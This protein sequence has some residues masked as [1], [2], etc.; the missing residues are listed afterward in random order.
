VPRCRSRV[1]LLLA[2]LRAWRQRQSQ[3]R[4][5]GRLVS[6]GDLV[7]DVGA[8]V[9]DRT[10]VLA[11][12][13]ARVVAVEPQEDCVRKLSRR[14]RE[15]QRVTVVPMGLG[16]QEGFQDLYVSSIHPLS[17]M[18]PAFVEATRRSGRFASVEWRERL[19]VPVTTLDQL[20]DRYGRPVFC[21]ID[22]EGYEAEVLRGLTAPLPLLSIEF[23]CE[24][25]GA[26][27][28]AVSYVESLGPSEFNYSLGESME[29][30]ADEWIT[31]PAL[32]DALIE[33]CHGDTL[34]WGDVYARAS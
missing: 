31:G 7:F 9:G 30:A 2:P 5:Y 4:F 17:T 23:I 18:T 13:G 14:F 28:E 16:A 33:A 21:K 6:P 10:A 27:N 19:S 22:V 25:L 20:I 26:T 3:T 11:S 8:N 24:R 1:P 29:F 12:L 32:L 34:V 15:K